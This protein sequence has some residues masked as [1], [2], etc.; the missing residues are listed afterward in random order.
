MAD[1]LADCVGATLVEAYAWVSACAVDAG[2]V[3]RAVVVEVA[4]VFAFPVFAHLAEGAIGVPPASGEAHAVAATIF[5][6]LT[7]LSGQ[8]VRIVEADFYAGSIYAT[9]AQ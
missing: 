4:S 5:R 3:L 2:S 7:E 1:R 8:A 6:L 9:L